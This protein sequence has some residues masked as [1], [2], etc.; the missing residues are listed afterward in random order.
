MQS[1]NSICLKLHMS[2]LI[3]NILLKKSLK[4]LLCLMCLTK[5]VLYNWAMY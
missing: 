2:S 3:F 5:K 1:I 4:H